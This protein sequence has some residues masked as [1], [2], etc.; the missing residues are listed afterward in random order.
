MAHRA[1]TDVSDD[2][3]ARRARD[4]DRAAFGAL[5][6]RHQA[7]ALRLA[8]AV[9]GSTEEARDIVQEAFVKAYRGIDRYR[10]DAPVRPWL[11]RIVANEAKNWGRGSSRRTRREVRHGSLAVVPPHTP[12]ELA[13]VSDDVRRV[14][15]ALTTMRG[16]DREVLAFRFVAGLSEAETAAAMGTSVG[17][18][19]SRTSR[20]LTRLRAVLSGGPEPTRDEE[21]Q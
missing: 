16:A 17:T 5:V 21:K 6:Q 13:E 14:A 19:K 11:L 3:L 7:A 12:E 9:V 8:T 10:G 15:A 18:V 20:A 1:T 4:G 2:D